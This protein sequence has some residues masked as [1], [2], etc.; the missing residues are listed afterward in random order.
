MA[1]VKVIASTVRYGSNGF[2]HAGDEYNLPE[3]KA[4][5]MAKAGLV[6]VI[7]LDSTTKS[8]SKKRTKKP[9]KVEEPNTNVAVMPDYQEQKPTE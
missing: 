2:K 3:E 7:S 5:E 6:R 4:K 1:L 8:Q 9:A